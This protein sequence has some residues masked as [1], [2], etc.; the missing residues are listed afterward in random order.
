MLPR[1]TLMR[2]LSFLTLIAFLAVPT[3]VNVLSSPGQNLQIVTAPHPV[4]RQIAVDISPD[5][6]KTIQQLIAIEDYLESSIIPIGGLALPQAGISKRGFVV[7][8]EGEAEIMINP[9]VILQGKLQKNL[10]GCLSLP[11]QFAYVN[12]NTKVTVSYRDENWNQRTLTLTGR[13]AFSVQHENDHI[14]GIL[15]TDLKI[16]EEPAVY[17]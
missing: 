11:W 15:F 8:V 9:V 13:Q 2:I 10:E 16:P 5:D 17:R 12:R 4:L 1:S 3:A 6:T 14:N 7:M